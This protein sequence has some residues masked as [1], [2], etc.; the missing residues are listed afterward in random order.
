M[1][2]KSFEIR[3]RGGSTM[4][5]REQ[6]IGGQRQHV[7]IADRLGRMTAQ[8]KEHGLRLQIDVL[9]SKNGPGDIGYRPQ[10]S[11]DHIRLTAGGVLVQLMPP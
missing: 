6:G 10:P 3:S 11:K 1:C 8:E 2:S 9:A 7:R 4:V 5:Q